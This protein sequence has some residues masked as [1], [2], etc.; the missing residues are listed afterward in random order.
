MTF[1]WLL[2]YL[3]GAGLMGRYCAHFCLSWPQQQRF[4]WRQEAHQILQ[5]N[6][7]DKAPKHAF[8]SSQ[9]CQHKLSYWQY[10]PLLSYLISKGA[11]PHCHSPMG[12]YYFYLE[13]LHLMLALTLFS[14]HLPTHQLILNQLLI[15]ALL[16]AAIID[17]QH[18]YIPDECCALA[19]VC[20]LSLFLNSPHMNQHVLAMLVAFVGMTCIRSSYY[21]L[22]KHQAMGL[23]DVKLYAVLAAW[24][25]MESLLG[26]LL[27]ASLMAILYTLIKHRAVSNHGFSEPT[28]FGPF[29]VLSAMVFFFIYA[30]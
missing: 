5:L 24:L 19:L 30:N 8:S 9:C 2:I 22:R 7:S 11:C 6:F 26:V 14:L 18:Q 23:G 21:W 13:C 15:S 29:L 28:S 1:D 25:G 3:L 27:G 16:C 4:L 12:K 10:I 17:Y 20:A